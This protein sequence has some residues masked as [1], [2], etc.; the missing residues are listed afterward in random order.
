[1]TRPG[2]PLRVLL[3]MDR[4]GY[5]N[6]HYHG[7]GRLMVEWTRA[8]L[9]QGV[10]VT[11]VVLREAG[12][13]GERARREGLPFVFLERGLYDPRTLLEMARLM[14]HHRIQ[15]A[16]LQGFGATAFGR[17]A[18]TLTGVPVIV[19]V[20]TDY[21]FEPKGYPWFVRLFDRALAPRTDL[22]LAVSEYARRF[23]VEVQGL[24]PERTRVVHSPVDLSCFSPASPEERAV[25]RSELGLADH[26]RA[27]V[28]VTRF[29]PVKGVDVLLESWRGIVAEVP[30]ARLLLAGEGPL[31]EELERM[32]ERTGVVETV[33][34]LGY[35]QDVRAFLSAG[36]L[37][38][39]PSR[40]EGF[41]LAGLEA[42][43][44]GVPVVATRVGG[45]PE[46]V[47][48]GENGVLVE[49]EDPTALAAAI[50][51]LLA[52]EAL[53]NRLAGRARESVRRYGLDAYARTLVDCYR[54]LL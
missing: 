17:V 31:R 6:E 22:A 27:V 44:C 14:R 15:V 1:M 35:R 3:S 38:V 21:R 41:C 24:P 52:D 30:A 46:L 11:P 2:E 25:Y 12:A 37:A 10:A 45:N 49:P 51:R 9:D 54:S 23:A 16:H 28:C 50:V 43:A 4:L 18:A 5:G 7:A 34:F 53:R 19:H 8:L 39:I 20:H 33:R 40:S 47:R 48:D 26:E 36:D 13:L 42:L 32:A 29:H